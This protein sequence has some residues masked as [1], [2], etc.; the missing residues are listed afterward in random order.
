MWM[1]E[2]NNVALRIKSAVQFRK[3]FIIVLVRMQHSC[4]TANEKT[5][6]MVQ[7]HLMDGSYETQNRHRACLLLRNELLNF[8]I[9]E[10]VV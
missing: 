4:L 1:A 9:L 8:P 7:M 6:W 5:G 2:W 10:R 3:I